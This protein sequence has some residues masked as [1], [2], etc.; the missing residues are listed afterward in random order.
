L[1]LI[2]QLLFRNRVPGVGIPIALQIYPGLC[3]QALVVLQSALRLRQR[4]L[5]RARIDVDEGFA[6]SHI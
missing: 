2:V 5:V 3:Q 1:D 6:L 4:R